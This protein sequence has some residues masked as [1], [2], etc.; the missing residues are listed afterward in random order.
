MVTASRHSRS[1]L[2]A[3]TLLLIVEAVGASIGV[4]GVGVTSGWG[5]LL[6][7]AKWLLVSLA[8]TAAYSAKVAAQIQERQ[9]PGYAEGFIDGSVPF[10]PKDAWVKVTSVR[11]SMGDARFIGMTGQ[12]VGHSEGQTSVLFGD[13]SRDSFW[14]EELVLIANATDREAHVGGEHSKV[15]LN[16]ADPNEEVVRDGV[17][18][19]WQPSGEVKHDLLKGGAPLEGWVFEEPHLREASEDGNNMGGPEPRVWRCFGRRIADGQSVMGVA[20]MSPG[21]STILDK[22]PPPVYKSDAMARVAARQDAVNK[23]R[24]VS[25]TP[26]VILF[27]Q[28]KAQVGTHDVEATLKF[29]REKFGQPPING[30]SYSEELDEVHFFTRH[31]ATYEQVWNALGDTPV[32]AHD[33]IDIAF[34]Q[35]PAGTH[36]EDIWRWIE[37]TYGVSVAR[38]QGADKPT[39]G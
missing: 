37:R 29:C 24:E 4:S 11:D 3:L 8:I 17:R 21:F 39:N 32:D 6:L 31:T 25:S 30:L 33:C 34:L 28:L 27:N 1:A 9:T 36:R 12:V 18:M 7:A 19:K 5:A 38:L 10:H 13:G 14:P 23:A 20:Y 16:P 22:E 35:F 15:T 2:L 26:D